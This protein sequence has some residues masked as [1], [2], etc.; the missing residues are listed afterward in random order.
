[1]KYE[2]FV[3]RCVAFLFYNIMYMQVLNT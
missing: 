1:M 2:S 3:M